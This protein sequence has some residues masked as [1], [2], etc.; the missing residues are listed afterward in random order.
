MKSAKFNMKAYRYK[1]GNYD[2]TIF[3]DGTKIRETEEDDFIPAFS[4]SIDLKITDRCDGGCPM[5]YEGCTA[6]GK[7]G[8]LNAPF[9]DTLHPYTEVAIN[10]ND[11]S[12]PDLLRFLTRMKNQ[13]VFVN[14][15]VN[16]KHFE[17]S[18][19]IIK[20][21]KDSNLIH[22][23]GISLE[24]A[25]T[26]FVDLA[27]TLNDV[28]IHTI[29]GVTKPSEYMR[30]Y[31]EGFKILVLGYKIKGRG[32]DYYNE[33]SKE[34]I[35]NILWLHENLDKLK[36]GFKII[37][38]DNLAVNQLPVKDLVSEEIWNECYMGDDGQFTFY[39]DLVNGKFGKNSMTS[40]EER[41]DI[42]GSIDEMFDVIR[43]NID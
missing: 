26:S 2:V 33:H 3:E 9:L 29:A 19:S 17:R 1:N 10:G 40:D 6:K 31:G 41:H 7:H 24:N 14:M 4:E 23:I 22:G 11:L 8:D 39:V 38:F 21:Y 32:V 5:C 13:K 18:Y 27:K 36:D 42:L 12:H 37:S 35:E 15:T 16:Q 43:G 28:V 34:I 30:L 20:H 25:T